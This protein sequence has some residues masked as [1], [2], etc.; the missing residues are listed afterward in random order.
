ML[1]TEFEG[2][3]ARFFAC[4]KR[5]W[6]GNVDP[7]A[8]FNELGWLNLHLAGSPEVVVD[9][10]WCDLVEGGEALFRKLRADELG[11]VLVFLNHDFRF[12]GWW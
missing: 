12:A 2:C 1:L 5:L 3:G 6:C 4:P 8:L 7:P 9:G 11:E 10:A